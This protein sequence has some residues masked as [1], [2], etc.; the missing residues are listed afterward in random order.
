MEPH[1]EAERRRQLEKIRMERRAKECGAAPVLVNHSLV[2]VP[3]AESREADTARLLSDVNSRIDATEL[4]IERA[5]DQMVD[6]M[7]LDDSEEMEVPVLMAGPLVK[8]LPPIKKLDL[9]A[10][11]QL[12]DDAGGVDVETPRVW[13]VGEQVEAVW[14]EDEVF[15][16]AEVVAYDAEADEY[17][18]L[19]CEYGNRQ[20]NTPA[21]LVRALSTPERLAEL[22][23]A[24]ESNFNVGAMSVADWT[25]LTDRIAKNLKVRDCEVGSEVF[26]RVF[27]GYAAVT[28]L[29]E[30]ESDIVQT[31][32][33][34]QKRKKK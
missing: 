12:E 9:S 5:A 28:W 27:D 20:S 17:E 26:R 23:L 4:S 29:L 30:T 13:K 24:A 34:E 15:Y 11:E 2:K 14:M 1:E 21:S 33:G 19:F 18:V 25:S 6:D 32:R 22:G 16:V 3:L 31:R 7:F 8:A 10:E